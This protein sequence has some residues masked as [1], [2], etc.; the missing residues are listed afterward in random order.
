MAKLLAKT[1]LASVLLLIAAAL[2][3]MYDVAQVRKLCESTVAG[4]L[5]EETKARAIQFGFNENK[6]SKIVNDGSAGTFLVILPA[7]RAL[8]ELACFIRHDG[9]RVVSSKMEG[10]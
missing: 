4:E 6:F 8:G 1:A 9:K 3:I 10:P 5:L 7:Q 2:W